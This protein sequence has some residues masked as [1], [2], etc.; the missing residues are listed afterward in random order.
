MHETNQAAAVTMRISIMNSATIV[1]SSSSNNKMRM[2]I[3]ATPHRSVKDLLKK[4]EV[5]ADKPMAKIANVPTKRAN[6]AFQKTAWQQA[7]LKTKPGLS[8][9][10]P[11]PT[12]PSPKTA[13]F[14][15]PEPKKA[16][17]LNMITSTAAAASSEP[18]KDYSMNSPAT[19]STV[20]LSPDSTAASDSDFVNIPTPPVDEQDHAA[21]MASS[22]INTTKLTTNP[23]SKLLLR[24]PT[25]ARVRIVSDKIKLLSLPFTVNAQHAAP[26]SLLVPKPIATRR[27]DIF[28]ETAAISTRTMAEEEKAECDQVLLPCLT[29]T[30]SSRLYKFPIKANSDDAANGSPAAVQETTTMTPTAESILEELLRL[31][32]GNAQLSMA[33]TI[34]NTTFSANDS[35][36]RTMIHSNSS[37]PLMVEQPLSPETNGLIQPMEACLSSTPDSRVSER[38]KMH[39]INLSPLFR[40]SLKMS[41]RGEPECK[42]EVSPPVSPP[43]LLRDSLQRQSSAFNQLSFNMD[44]HIYERIERD[45]GDDDEDNEDNDD[46]DDYSLNVQPDQHEPRDEDENEHENEEGWSSD[47]SS[48]DGGSM[49]GT[50]APVGGVAIEQALMDATTITTGQGNDRFAR[51]VIPNFSRWSRDDESKLDHEPDAACYNKQRHD[52][53]VQESIAAAAYQQ[54]YYQECDLYQHSP[55]NRGQSSTAQVHQSA[56]TVSTLLT[57]SSRLRASYKNH[58]ALSSESDEDDDDDDD[59]VAEICRRGNLSDRALGDLLADSNSEGEASATK[60]SPPRPPPQFVASLCSSFDGGCMTPVNHDTISQEGDEHFVMQLA[61]PTIESS[62][63]RHKAWFRRRPRILKKKSKAQTKNVLDDDL[64]SLHAEPVMYEYSCMSPES[65]AATEEEVETVLME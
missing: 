27:T 63:R 57:S 22:N 33:S 34:T 59:N 29:P 5:K 35:P 24:K 2:E 37:P 4:Y 30:R 8:I 21:T 45:D 48:G 42:Q 9:E 25:T 62:R 14:D 51:K 20:E 43:R 49:E 3:D 32:A 38:S 13:A 23:S 46:N 16:T 41:P 39:A 15:S 54:Q 1:S 53:P 26:S 11:L 12:E 55:I 6:A 7:D 31:D 61:A 56:M 52:Y 47:D 65:T 60:Q 40:A 17:L 50:M 18:L 64:A 10:L 28:E 19:C 58:E 44:N 36:D